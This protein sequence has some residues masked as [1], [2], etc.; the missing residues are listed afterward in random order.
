MSF[1]Y[2][3]ADPEELLK[4]FQLFD[5][6]NRGYILRNDLEKAITEMG[7]PFNAQE[8]EEMM[9]IACDAKTNK[10]N[11]EYYINLLIVSILTQQF[12]CC[13]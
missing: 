5:P 6:D 3:P 12:I 13:I 1:R 2:K 9:S 8:V 10:I 4:A 7:E 11:Y